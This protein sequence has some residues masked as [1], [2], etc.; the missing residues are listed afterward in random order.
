M[1]GFVA[2]DYTNS[3]IV[4]AFRG[5]E[6][7]T[8]GLLNFRYALATTDI[9][10]GCL[11]HSGFWQAYQ[12]VRTGIAG[13]VQNLTATN[14]NFTV[15]ATGHSLGAALATLTAIDLR[16][17]RLNVDLVRRIIMVGCVLY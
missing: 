11:S 6:G 3:L 4:V 5:T 1:N 13:A 17:Q 9:C 16:K 2:V 14:Q 8:N 7:G 15:L 10:D 12:E